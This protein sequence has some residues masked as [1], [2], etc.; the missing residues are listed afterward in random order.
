MCR[1]NKKSWICSHICCSRWR[2]FIKFKK[3]CFKCS[4]SSSAFNILFSPPSAGLVYWIVYCSLSPSFFSLSL[5]L[6]LFLSHSLFLDRPFVYF[7][8]HFG[9]GRYLISA[10]YLRFLV[11]NRILMWRERKREREQE[12]TTQRNGKKGITGYEEDEGKCQ[13]KKVE[14]VSSRTAA[15]PRR[16]SRWKSMKDCKIRQESLRPVPE[17][18]FMCLSFEVY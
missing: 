18:L 16:R 7:D 12:R 2:L 15:L 3:A 6:S 10:V 11:N 4:Y 9:I 8:R 13:G 5:S 17:F 1:V 14:E